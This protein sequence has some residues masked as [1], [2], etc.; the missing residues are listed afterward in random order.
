MSKKTKIK[1]LSLITAFTL[2]VGVGIAFAFNTKE[3]A[4]VETRSEMVWFTYNNEASDVNEPSNYTLHSED[5]EN[6]PG[7]AGAGRLCAIQAERDA[8]NPDQPNLATQTNPQFK[9]PIQ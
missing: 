6:S 7:C 8:S 3:K 2:F 9:N 4:K 1:V 5:P